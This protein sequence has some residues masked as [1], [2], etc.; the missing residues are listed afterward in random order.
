MPVELISDY[1][2]GADAR[3]GRTIG[4]D[5][6][7]AEANHRIANNLALIAGMVH[8]RANEI[9]RDGQS[10]SAND[11]RVVLDEVGSRIQTVGR[12]HRLLAHT[13]QTSALN[14]HD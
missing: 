6:M 10:F 9:A 13:G 3:T 1:L 14:L 8:L 11:V 12:L 2:A 7:I 5:V 4:S